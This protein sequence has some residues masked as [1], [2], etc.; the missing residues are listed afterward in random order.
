MPNDSSDNPTSNQ[1]QPVDQYVALIMLIGVVGA[2][3]LGGLT[4]LDEHNTPMA[5]IAAISG[6]VGGALFGKAIIR[7]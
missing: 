5:L 3:L 7:R 6:F 4:Y 1:D 2:I